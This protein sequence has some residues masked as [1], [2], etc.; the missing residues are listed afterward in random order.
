M[1]MKI[2]VII[3]IRTRDLSACSAG[4]KQNASPRAPCMYTCVCAFSVKSFRACVFTRMH[5]R[6]RTHTHTHTLAR[7]L[8]Y[9]LNMHLYRRRAEVLRIVVN[10]SVGNVRRKS[11]VVLQVVPEGWR[12]HNERS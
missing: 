7:A 3:W 12:W 8:C 1:S 2:P 10:L 4:P 6:A 9:L 11:W 5:A